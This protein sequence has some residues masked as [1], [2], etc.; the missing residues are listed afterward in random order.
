M[1]ENF[2]LK[3]FCKLVQWITGFIVSSMENPKKA[4]WWLKYLRFKIPNN[5]THMPKYKPKKWVFF[6]V[7][8]LQIP[9]VCI[10]RKPINGLDIGLLS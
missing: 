2:D 6:A 3:L 9:R 10:T 7:V 1:I 8:V 4:C 5:K